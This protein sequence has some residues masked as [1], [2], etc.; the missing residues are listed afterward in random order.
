MQNSNAGWLYNGSVEKFG[1]RHHFK[2]REGVGHHA[3]II[4]DRYIIIIICL[5]V[6]LFIWLPFSF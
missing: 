2:S 1:A 3:D 6:L 4:R 5:K